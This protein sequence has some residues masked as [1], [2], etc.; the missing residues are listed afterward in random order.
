VAICHGERAASD[1]DPTAGA[2]VVLDRLEVWQGSR[3]RPGKL[4]EVEEWIAM[5]AAGFNGAGVILDPWQG[6]G[7]AQR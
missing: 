3:L 7:L 1:A 6:S 4:D 2:K 5:A